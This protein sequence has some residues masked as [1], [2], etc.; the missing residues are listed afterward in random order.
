MRP[1]EQQGDEPDRSSGRARAS[2]P[3]NR[4]LGQAIRGLRRARGLTIEDLA[5]A[6][7]MHST[8]LSGIERGGTQPD[9]G[10]DAFP[11]PNL[12]RPDRGDR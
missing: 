5:F 9:M 1:K 11:R 10:Q 2:V 6:A 12:R 7:D 8:Y 4:D 3:S